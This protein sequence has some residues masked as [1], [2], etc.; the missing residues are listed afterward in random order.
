MISGELY[1][2]RFLDLF[3]GSGGIGIEALS[4][5]AQSASFV[6]DSLKSIDIIK[7][8]L[9]RARLDD[10]AEVIKGNVLTT[11]ASLGARGKRFDIIFMDPPYNKGLVEASL[12]VIKKSGVLSEDGFIIA[13]QATEEKELTVDGFTVT[14]IKQFGRTTKMTFLKADI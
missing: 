3:S 10:K 5:G 4:R 14:R 1:D 13:E 11:I 8:N 2:S 9:S 6:D 7:D 12:E